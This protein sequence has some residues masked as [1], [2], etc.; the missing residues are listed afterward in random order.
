MQFKK[1]TRKALK[2]R[3]ALIGPSGSGK[4]MTA[5]RIATVLADGGTVGVIDTETGSAS[6][7]AG[8]TTS[9]GTVLDFAV[10]ELDQHSPK[11]YVKAIKAAADAGVDALV[12]DSLSHAWAGKGGALEMVD[13]AARRNR[14]NSFG[15]WRDV[16][17]QHNAMVEAILQAP[18]H[19]VCTMRAKTA[20]VQEKD[21]KTGR[22]TV[23]KVGMQP[24]QRDGM[25]YEFTLTADIDQDHHM[26]IGKTRCSAVADKVY[27]S[28][29]PELARELLEW[30]DGGAPVPTPAE[31]LQAA[32]E[33]SGVTDEQLGAWLESK[34]KPAV[35]DMDAQTLRK[36]AQYVSGNSAMIKEVAD[37]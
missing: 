27:R 29:G 34:G 4:T 32:L 9:D 5:L 17:P 30:L 7:Y 12:I 14:G 20:F 10:L 21:P 37:D 26:I 2:L 15:A 13:N 16:T 8:E 25:E 3:I 23:R 18:M 36:V 11:D 28:D 35:G 1:A 24:V 22:T 31:E 19:I 6:L 33:A